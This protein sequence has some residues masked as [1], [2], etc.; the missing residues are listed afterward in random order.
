MLSLEE[1]I[2]ISIRENLFFARI[3]KEHLIFVGAALPISNCELILKVEEFKDVWENFLLESII[4]SGGNVDKDALKYNELITPYTLKAEEIT[5][6]Y[7]GIHINTELTKLEMNLVP[8]VNPIYPPELEDSICELNKR[9]IDLTTE[10]IK[11]K[12]E[13]QKSVNDCKVFIFLYLHLL[14]HVVEEAEL[15]LKILNALQARD[16]VILKDE[17]LKKEVF[18]NEKMKDHSEFIRGLLDTSEVDLFNMANDFAK[19]FDKL[20]K[21]AQKAIDENLP[22]TEVTK[23]SKEATK[24]IIKFKTSGTTGLIDC[25]IKAIILPLLA[26]HVLREAN[27]Y[28]RILNTLSEC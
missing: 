10:L 15:Y 1:Y 24:N 14:E 17:L 6:Y 20:T 18:W 11:L 12:E 22:G 26:D 13:L 23:K 3:M 25:K 5:N 16:E 2:N 27:H 9:G 7:T 4:L 21:E 28:Y 19:I 8:S